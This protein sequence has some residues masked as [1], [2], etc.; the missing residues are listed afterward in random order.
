MSCAHKS[1]TYKHTDMDKVMTVADF[2]KKWI[3]CASGIQYYIV[4]YTLIRLRF[5]FTWRLYRF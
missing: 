3:D 4:I 5:N 1:N 2:P